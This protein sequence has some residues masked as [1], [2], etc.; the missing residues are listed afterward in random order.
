MKAI[1]VIF[2]FCLSFIGCNKNEFST[3][4]NYE[5]ENHI[6]ANFK[7]G[8]IEAYAKSE[9]DGLRLKYISSNNVD[10]H[11]YSNSWTYNYTKHLDSSLESKHYF[12]SSFYDSIHCDSIVI[13]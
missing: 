3:E 6:T 11:G 9:D 5:G 2:V 1:I 4:N 8:A 12:I 10:Y 7:S 13:R